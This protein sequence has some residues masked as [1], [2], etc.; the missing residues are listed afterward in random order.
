M[1]PE[2]KHGGSSV[3]TERYTLV[4][5]TGMPD[6]HRHVHNTGNIL[7]ADSPIYKVEMLN[8]FFKLWQ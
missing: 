3:Y 5:V 2:I 4:G 6:D 8:I 1:L 7:T